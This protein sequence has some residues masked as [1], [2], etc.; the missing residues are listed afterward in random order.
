MMIRRFSLLL[1]IC[2][3]AIFQG[4]ASTSISNRGERNELDPFE[5]YN[6]TVFVFNDAADRLILKPVATV[7]DRYTPELF[8]FL[9][10]NFLSNLGELNNGV[11]NLLQGKV[12]FALSDTTRFFLNSTLGFGGLADVATDLGLERSNEDFGQTLGYWG[13]R[14]GPYLVLPLLG[15]SSLRDLSSIP[16]STAVSPTPRLFD[17]KGQVLVRSFDLLET[18]AG[19]L[20]ASRLMDGVALDPYTFVRNAYFQR[21]L[22]L[23]Y[24][25]NPPFHEPPPEDREPK[26]ANSTESPKK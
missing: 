20:G 24:D 17:T 19:L 6:R 9:A 22:S 4:C 14:P 1:S 2:A 10:G 5:V 25:G 7:Y 15:P 11:N 26:A 21:R 18:R 16:A 8:R 3:F 12:K 13:F 23:V